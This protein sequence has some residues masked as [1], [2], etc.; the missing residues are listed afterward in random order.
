VIRIE[1]QDDSGEF[2]EIVLPD[3]DN[4]STKYSYDNTN[5]NNDD[6][7]NT[8]L[9]EAKDILY[10][11]LPLSSLQS[12]YENLSANEYKEALGNA[13]TILPQAKILKSEKII[14]KAKNIYSKIEQIIDKN[15]NKKDVK[16]LKPQS[17]SR[18]EVLEI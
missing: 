16:I 8:L 13:I 11:I 5:N 4:G 15:K 9:N 10:E 12:A 18:E 1:T 7:L 3:N 17:L 14:A 6:E 2:I